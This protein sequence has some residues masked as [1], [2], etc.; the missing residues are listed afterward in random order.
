M[1]IKRG[2]F[3]S[4]IIVVIEFLSVRYNNFNKLKNNVVCKFCY[5]E[6]EI[7]IVICF[8]LLELSV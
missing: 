6:F 4:R 8:I 1:K 5:I 2:K 7:I 3:G